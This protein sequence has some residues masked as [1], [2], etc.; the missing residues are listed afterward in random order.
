MSVRDRVLS[1]V[2]AMPP[3][4]HATMDLMRL[5]QM[6]D[7]SM[8]V[9][10]PKIQYD[11][12]LTANVLALAN[13]AYFGCPG[14]VG[15]LRE[16][17]VRLG[18]TRL[19]QLVMASL[20]APRLKP[21]V[22]GYDMPPDEL[23]RHSVV[24]AVAAE[25][26]ASALKMR[27]PAHTF[28]AALLHDI[29]KIVLG[30]FLEVDVAPIMALASEKE[31]SFEEAEKEVLGIDHAE[32]GT[33]LLAQWSLPHEIVEAIKYHHRPNDLNGD[34]TLVD[35]VHTA[36][37]LVIAGGIGIGVDGLQYRFCSDTA[38]RLSLN[39]AV[40]EQAEC[41]TLAAMEELRLV[42]GLGTDNAEGKG[43]GV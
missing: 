34:R 28:T 41:N 33:A 2:R 30:T 40:L 36:D 38:D 8:A 17:V 27:A 26:L 7:V 23:W 11:P 19:R 32:T 16:A 9:L 6:D 3:V 42:F 12:G 35:L 21:A 25:Q 39:E 43:F 20:A 22:R 24:T 37:M 29:G 1:E 14:E 13:S 5:L 18:I 4:P 31:L 10:L 15:T